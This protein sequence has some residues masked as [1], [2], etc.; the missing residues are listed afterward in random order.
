MSETQYIRWK[1]GLDIG[2]EVERGRAFSGSDR[3]T[4]PAESVDWVQL[5]VPESVKVRLYSRVVSTGGDPFNIDLVRADS[6]TDGTTEFAHAG[7]NCVVGELPQARLF[8]GASS[9]VNPV[10]LE[11]GRIPANRGPQSSG[12]T[13]VDGTYRILNGSV[14]PTL[15]RIENTGNADRTVNLL[16]VWTEVYS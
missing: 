11:Y 7:L 1:A 6:V 15:L 14:D 9:P 2:R 4:I 12:A 8:R 10:T 16:F 13:Q 3:W 5:K